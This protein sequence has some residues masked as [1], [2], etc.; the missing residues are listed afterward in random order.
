MLIKDDDAVRTDIE[1][2]VRVAFVRG[3]EGGAKR[4]LSL[5]DILSSQEDLTAELRRPVD[6]PTHDGWYDAEAGCYIDDGPLHSLEEQK[7][8]AAAIPA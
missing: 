7:E 1:D 4:D 8:S 5:H 6:P 3:D 2:E